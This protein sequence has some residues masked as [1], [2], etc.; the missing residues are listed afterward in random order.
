MLDAQP[1]LLH[2][3][4][5]RVVRVQGLVPQPLLCL[6]LSTLYSLL[7]TG[8]CK[9]QIASRKIRVRVRVKTVTVRVMVRD[10]RV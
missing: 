4:L 5:L 2:C 7:L 9:L 1:T 6:L 8:E 3:L 10:V